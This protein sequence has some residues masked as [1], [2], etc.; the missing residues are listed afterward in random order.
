MGYKILEKNA[1][2]RIK[3]NISLESKIFI[4]KGNYTQIRE[5]LLQRGW[6]ENPDHSSNIFDFKW[7]VKSDEAYVSDLH[8]Y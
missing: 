4:M 2:K 5:A 6:I 8:D 3:Q 7:T 1:C